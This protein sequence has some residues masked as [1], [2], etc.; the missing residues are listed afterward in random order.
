DRL[1][2]EVGAADLTL[3]SRAVVKADLSD[4]ASIAPNLGDLEAAI[5]AMQ[6]KT[7]VL[8]LR[9]VKELIGLHRFS[10]AIA[11]AS[12][13]A[14]SVQAPVVVRFSALLFIDHAFVRQLRTTRQTT[15]S[16]SEVHLQ[17]AFALRRITRR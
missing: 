9:R 10:E 7:D 6:Q 1:V 2:S 14:E 8:V 12:P 5:L 17:T 4:F 3:A 16:V 11:A 15:P 13:I